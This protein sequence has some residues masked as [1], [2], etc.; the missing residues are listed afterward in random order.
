VLWLY[1][2]PDRLAL[3]DRLSHTRVVRLSSS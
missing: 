1:V 3:H 2:D